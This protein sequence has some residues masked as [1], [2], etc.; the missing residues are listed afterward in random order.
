MTKFLLS[1]GLFCIIVAAL[2]VVVEVLI[3]TR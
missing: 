1:F 3:Y 2:V